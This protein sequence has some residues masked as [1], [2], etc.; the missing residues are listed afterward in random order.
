MSFFKKLFGTPK[1]NTEHQPAI[2]LRMTEL[3]LEGL[4]TDLAEDEK[5]IRAILTSL[6]TGHSLP[7]IEKDL[8]DLGLTR[9]DIREL[10]QRA[11]VA[12]TYGDETSKKVCGGDLRALAEFQ[13]QRAKR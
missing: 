9:E 4:K 11:G 7:D 6:F 13:E 3:L 5:T 2:M 1:Y 12:K 8:I 10:M